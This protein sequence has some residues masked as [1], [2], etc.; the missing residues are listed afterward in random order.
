MTLIIIIISVIILIIIIKDKLEYIFKK[1]YISIKTS[2]I[3]YILALIFLGASFSTVMYSFSPYKLSEINVLFGAF[4]IAWLVGFIIPGVPGGIGVREA[5]LILYLENIINSQNILEAVV[6][7]RFISVIADLIA[8][9]ISI[10]IFNIKEINK[11]D[12]IN[13]E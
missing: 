11:E 8:Y 3:Y 10:I 4:A 9:I 12:F 13:E 7:H 2:L 6:I 1:I 5:I